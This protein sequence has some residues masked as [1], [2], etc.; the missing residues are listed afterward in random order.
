MQKNISTAI[1]DIIDAVHKE[2][3]FQNELP[4][5]AGIALFH[6]LGPQHPMSLEYRKLFD[7]AIY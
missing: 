7:M 4:R 6:L 5:R 3:A 2:P 1:E